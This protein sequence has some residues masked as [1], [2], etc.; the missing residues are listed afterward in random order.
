MKVGEG[1]LQCNRY[2]GHYINN[3]LEFQRLPKHRLI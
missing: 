2:N 3:E 1:G